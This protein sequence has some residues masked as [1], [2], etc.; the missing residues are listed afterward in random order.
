MRRR[1]LKIGLVVCALVVVPLG[2][3]FLVYP[4]FIGH[5]DSVHIVVNVASTY[6][7]QQPTI[8]FDHWFSQQS[9][10]VYTALVAGGA[11]TGVASCPAISNNRPYYHY[12]LTFS[13]W[14][15]TTATAISDAVGCMYFGVQYPLGV[16]EGYSWFRDNGPSFWMQLHQLVNAPVPDA[17]ATDSYCN[18]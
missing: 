3:R 14:G 18:G 9:T 5:P 16:T 15:M 7:D 11:L 12:E 10:D 1:W 2:I 4:I 8:I 17:C 6:P 13:R